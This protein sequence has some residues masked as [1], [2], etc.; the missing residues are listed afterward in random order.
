MDG[1]AADSSGAPRVTG[2]CRVVHAAVA[3]ST[4]GETRSLFTLCNFPS[5]LDRSAH[6]SVPSFRNSM[7]NTSV[8]VHTRAKKSAAEFI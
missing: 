4:T 8:S 5:R 2:W 6:C 1:T 7:R 3:K